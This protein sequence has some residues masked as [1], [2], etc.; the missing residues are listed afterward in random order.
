MERW[1]LIDIRNSWKPSLICKI[2][3]T[4]WAL[5]SS[6]PCRQRTLTKWGA[7]RVRYWSI[8]LRE[9]AWKRWRSE[10]ITNIIYTPEGFDNPVLLTS[11]RTRAPA[12]FASKRP[13]A[14]ASKFCWFASRECFLRSWSNVKGTDKARCDTWPETVTFVV[15]HLPV[16]GISIIN[17][18]KRSSTCLTA[19]MTFRLS[20]TTSRWGDN[21][22][23]LKA[24]FYISVK[25]GLRLIESGTYPKSFQ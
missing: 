7:S 22:R 10:I 17:Q 2:Y 18:T 24:Q 20:R 15:L 5:C 8:R 25:L 9:Y 6:R 16:Q 4:L 23:R 21:L 1:V 14:M 3:M 13:S 19:Y 12:M 11:D